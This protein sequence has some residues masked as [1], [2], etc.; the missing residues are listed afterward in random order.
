MK[1]AH[2]E[3]LQQFISLFSEGL[4]Y[5]VVVNLLHIGLLLQFVLHHS[6]SQS[7]AVIR[8][9]YMSWYVYKVIRLCEIAEQ[10]CR[11]FE[12]SV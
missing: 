9:L 2:V 12:G 10:V 11:C 5:E 1:L 6:E 4:S 7:P 8:S 3:S